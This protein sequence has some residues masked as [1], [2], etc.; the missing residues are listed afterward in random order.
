[1]VKLL[2]TLLGAAFCLGAAAAAAHA[3]PI[4]IGVGVIGPISPQTEADIDSLVGA[5]PNVKAVPIQPPG[6]VDAC[7]KRFVA[8]E[9]DDRL[10]AVMVVSLPVDSFQTQRDANEARFTGAYEIWTLNLST[11]AEDRHRFTFSDSE[12]VI[13]GATAILAMPAQL[14]AERATGKKLISSDQWQAFEAVQARVESKLVAATKLYLATAPIRD[15]TP[16]NSLDTAKSLLDRG[17][18]ETAMAV[19]KSSG[20]NNPEVQRM[21]AAAQVQ[22]R[23]IQAQALLG[24]TLGAMAGGNAAKARTLIDEYEKAPTAESARA[25]SIRRVLATDTDHR[26]NSIYD[27]VLRSDVPSLDHAAFVAMIKQLF[28]EETGSAPDEI[29]V[30][31]K[32]VTIA[33]KAAVKGVKE[34]LDTYAGAVGRSAW[35]MSL[36]CGCEAGAV[37]TGE[38]VG[39]AIMK[40]K[41]AP[42]FKRAQVGLP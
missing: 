20:L 25:D 35:L 4:K 41:F 24:K 42:S 29:V 10:D 9:A 36:K 6:D 27:G 32:D 39:G 19:F 33:D 18:G 23:R 8:G 7:V 26:A 34:Q 2:A 38:A 30:G 5:L 37:L 21:I 1:M 3:A 22:M 17:D 14:F 16:L 28:S 11:L 12:P 31:A 40:A 13:G 15:T